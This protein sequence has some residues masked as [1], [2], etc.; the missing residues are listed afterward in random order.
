MTKSHAKPYDMI[1]VVEPVI[2]ITGDDRTGTVK[3]FYAP[4]IYATF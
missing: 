3:F 1:T 2:T 4:I